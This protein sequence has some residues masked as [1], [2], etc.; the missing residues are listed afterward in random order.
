MG[1]KLN[2]CGTSSIP[3]TFG[4]IL[5]VD[6]TA[7]TLTLGD[8]GEDPRLGTVVFVLGFS[9][10]ALLI[11]L[12]PALVVEIDLFIPPETQLDN[13]LLVVSLPT[14]SVGTTISFSE[15]GAFSGP[16]TP[17]PTTVAAHGS[18]DQYIVAD[19]NGSLYL[20]D[21]VANRDGTQTLPTDNTVTFT[22]GTGVFDPT[23]TAEDVARIYQAALGRGPDVA[24]IEFWNNDVDNLHAPLSAVANSFATSPEF[25]HTYGALDNPG[26]V[27]QLYLNVLGRAADLGGLQFWENTLASGGTRGDVLLAFSQSPEFKVRTLSTAGDQNDAEAS[28]IYAAAFGRAPDASGEA[29]WSSQLASGATPMQVAQ[30]FASSTE[31]QNDF[32]TLD[33]SDFVNDLY[34][35]VLHRS[36]DPGGQSFWTNFLNQGGSKATVVAGFADSIENRIQTAAATHAN[37]VFIPS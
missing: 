36:G 20:Q 24:G 33:A 23:G 25:M 14:L 31:F 34:E 7:D 28:R 16:L 4:T 22:D 26:F 3:G 10:N 19:N 27:N 8:P 5:Q 12:V 21:T 32:G 37:W 6:D 11:S 17:T 18:H 15:S 13:S 30:G 1:S 2:A 29:F 9:Q 35:N